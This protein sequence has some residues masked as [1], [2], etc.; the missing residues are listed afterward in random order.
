M[1]LYEGVQTLKQRIGLPAHSDIRFLSTETG[2]P[3][4]RRREVDVGDLDRFVETFDA[5]MRVAR[6]N[7]NVARIFGAQVNA[8]AEL[9]FAGKP[10]NTRLSVASLL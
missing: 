9:V 2:A 10:V 1:S 5:R 6:F 8:R 7:A 3:L 4:R